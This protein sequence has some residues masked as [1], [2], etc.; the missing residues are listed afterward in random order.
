[1]TILQLIIL[2]G[3]I[4][5]MPPSYSSGFQQSSSMMESGPQMNVMQ[6]QS[7]YNQPGYSQGMGGMAPSRTAQSYMGQQPLTQQQSQF[8]QPSR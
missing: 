7:S 1:M 2:Y 5:G 3:F 4:A 6:P 8:S